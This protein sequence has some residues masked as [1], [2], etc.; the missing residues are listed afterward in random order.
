LGPTKALPDPVAERLP[1]QQRRPRDALES[2]PLG[3][4]IAKPAPRALGG[5][6]VVAGVRGESFE[7]APDGAEH[8][9]PLLVSAW[10]EP[11]PDRVELG[12]HGPSLAGGAGRRRPAELVDLPLARDVIVDD[13][14]RVAMQRLEEIRELADV[15]ER[16]VLD[17][18]ARPDLVL[19]RP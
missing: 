2:E 5:L 7:L 9:A 13:P 12:D 10:T 18:L 14:V 11:V 19:D 16:R 8:D 1:A 17:T 15:L 4:L 6:D 3:H